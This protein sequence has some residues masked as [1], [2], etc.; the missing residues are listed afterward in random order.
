MP[1]PD[2]SAPLL[3]ADAPAENAQRSD[4][5]VPGSA[6]CLLRRLE[7]PHHGPLSLACGLVGVLG[8]IVEALM[9]AVVDLQLQLSVMAA[10]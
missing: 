10:P 8:P 3:G 9:L 2:G 4:Q 7:P 5:T 1:S 6:V